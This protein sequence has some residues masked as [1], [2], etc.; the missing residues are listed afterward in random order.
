VEKHGR[1]RQAAEN[2]I[3]CRVRFACWINKAT[4]TH[5]EY[6]ILIAFPEQQWLHVSISMLRYTYTV[7]LVGFCVIAKCRMVP[8]VNLKHTAAFVVAVICSCV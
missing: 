7:C 4:D 2:N 3:I 5:S 6:V 8:C 1:A